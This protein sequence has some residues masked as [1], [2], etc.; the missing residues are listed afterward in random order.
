MMIWPSASRH[1]GLRPLEMLALRA[2]WPP[3][4][5]WPSIM[6][7]KLVRICFIA[8]VRFEAP[9]GVRRFRRLYMRDPRTRTVFLQ[10]GSWPPGWGKTYRAWGIGAVILAMDEALRDLAN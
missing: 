9:S 10:E 5:R 3:A 1:E 8:L 7:G 2:T 6:M 4:V